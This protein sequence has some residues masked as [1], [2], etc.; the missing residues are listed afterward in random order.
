[1]QKPVSQ[2]RGASSGEAPKRVAGIAT[3]KK[4]KEEVSA[5]G[6]SLLPDNQRD[7][8]IGAPRYVG[9]IMGLYRGS[10]V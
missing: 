8:K 10:N 1:M 2:W 5:K 6:F 7:L 4:P 3:A 9:V